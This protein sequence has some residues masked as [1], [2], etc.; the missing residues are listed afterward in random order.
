MV[1]GLLAL[2]IAGV[3]GYLI[4]HKATAAIDSN[5]PVAVVDVGDLLASLAQQKLEQQG[6]QS[7][8][9]KEASATVGEDRVIS[10]N[11][12][13]GVPVARDTVV[14]L[15]VSTGKPKSTVP[16]VKG[17]S[18]T[19]A[20]SDLASK[21]L[22]FKVFKV[23]SPTVAAGTVTATKPAAGTLVLEGSTVQINVSQGPQTVQVPT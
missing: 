16:E 8:V 22:R 11:P 4:Y 5:R 2:A 6:L 15:T 23:H 21:G 7:R 17:E 19:Q 9:E 1:L 20:V 12:G 10:Q 3:G 18:E 14:T 13:P